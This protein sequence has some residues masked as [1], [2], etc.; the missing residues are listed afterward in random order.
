MPGCVYFRSFAA[1]PCKPPEPEHKETAVKAI[2]AAVEVTGG[3][4]TPIGAVGDGLLADRSASAASV[5]AR[6]RRANR[7]AKR[8]QEASIRGAVKKKTDV[9]H[10]YLKKRA[11]VMACRDLKASLRSQKR[12]AVSFNLETVASAQARPAAKLKMGSLNGS[13]TPWCWTGPWPC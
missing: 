5:K 8:S 11:W 7:A 3:D 10:A 9:K 1:P 12:T 13:R 4:P 6:S 2:N